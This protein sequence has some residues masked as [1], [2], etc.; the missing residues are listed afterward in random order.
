MASYITVSLCNV[1]AWASCVAV[2]ALYRYRC[3]KIG[4]VI[5][6][7]TNR[8]WTIGVLLLLVT[9]LGILESLS[10]LKVTL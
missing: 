1:I 7:L 9:A 10:L 3:K 2:I 5:A 4:S 8:F 6:S